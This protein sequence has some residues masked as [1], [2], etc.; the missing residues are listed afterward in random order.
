[1]DVNDDWVI[2]YKFDGDRPT[3]FREVRWFGTTVWQATGRPK[4]FGESFSVDFKTASETMAAFCE[5][6]ADAKQQGFQRTHSG[7]YRHHGID[8]THLTAA[9]ITGAKR[10]FETMRAAHPDQTL[11]FF[12]LFSDDGAMTIVPAAN[13]KEAVL[14]AADDDE[15]FWNISAW[16]FDD[17]DEYLDPAYRMILPPFRDIPCDID[18]DFSEMIFEASVNALSQLRDEHFFGE[19]NDDLVILFQVSDSDYGIELN[20]RL[21]TKRTYQRYARWMGV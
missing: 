11:T 14:G 20:Q 3:E 18:D 4:T 15:C 6:C 9:I 17:G 5:A 19:P 16:P 2:F 1:M 8:R 21:N 13:S 10:S 12:G 7:N